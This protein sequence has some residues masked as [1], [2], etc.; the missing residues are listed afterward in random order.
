MIRYF[1]RIK[2]KFL[3][4]NNRQDYFRGL[5]TFESNNFSPKHISSACIMSEIF[6]VIMKK[7]KRELHLFSLLLLS[8]PLPSLFMLCIKVIQRTIITLY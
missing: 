2:W 1:I 6:Q 8:T 4:N 3:R 5:Y 7:E